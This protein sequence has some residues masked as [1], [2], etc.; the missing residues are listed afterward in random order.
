M[1]LLYGFAVSSSIAGDSWNNILDLTNGFGVWNK[2][3]NS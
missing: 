2:D 1:K 3:R